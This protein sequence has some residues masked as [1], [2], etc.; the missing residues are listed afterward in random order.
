[1]THQWHLISERV[2]KTHNDAIKRLMDEERLSRLRSPSATLWFQKTSEFQRWIQSSCGLLFY[3]DINAD[4]MSALVSSVVLE[5]AL[6]ELSPLKTIYV[7]GAQTANTGREDQVEVLRSLLCQIICIHPEFLD[8]LRHNSV[9]ERQLYSQTLH[10]LLG[11]V[12]DFS[13]QEAT[14]IL[15]D[16]LAAGLKSQCL[17]AYI[18]LDRFH[19]LGATQEILS[20][21]FNALKDAAH[22]MVVS[23]EFASLRVA[24]VNSIII[25]VETERRGES[26]GI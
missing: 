25:D 2:V 14:E 12:A 20:R 6:P 13:A 21:V 15:L 4:D 9:A 7:D 8:G 3:L 18:I 22:T 11:A 19:S 23:E 17:G 10:C 1:M 16:A 26:P 5:G 24:A